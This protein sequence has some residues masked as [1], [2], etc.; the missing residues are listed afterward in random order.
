MGKA[1]TKESREKVLKEMLQIEGACE[2]LLQ[3]FF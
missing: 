1:I 3:S 2:E